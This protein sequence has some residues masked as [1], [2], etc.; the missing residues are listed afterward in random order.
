M[1]GD[2]TPTGELAAFLAD[3]P[4]DGA[5]RGTATDWLLDTLGCI[6]FGAGRPESAAAATHARASGGTGGTA[7]VVGHGFATSPALAAFANGTSGHAFELDDV[8]EEAISHPGAVVVPA[9]LAVAPTV[10][11]SGRTVVDAIVVGYEAMGRAGIAVGPAAHM[12]S[13]FH[14]TG[15]SGVFG[16]AAA[17]GHLLGFDAAT[18]AHALGLAATFA[19]GS[20]EFSQTG[21]STKRFHAGR[22]SEG[23]LTAAM[24][25][26]AGMEG[27]ADGLAGRYG[28]CRTTTTDPRI[29]L[30][31]E[32]LGSRWMVDEVTVKPWAACSDIHPLIDAAVE[33][34]ARGVTADDIA[35]IHAEVP[36]KAAEQN[37]LDGT[38][39]VMAAQYSGPFNVAAAFLADPA[40]PATY[41]P[42]RIAD[43]ALADLQS[44]VVSMRA[45][46]WCDATYAWK[47][48]GSL[49][50][51]C[52]DGTEHEVRVAGQKGSMHQP[53]TADELEQ[54]FRLLVDDRLDADALLA[55]V[56]GLLDAPDARTLLDALA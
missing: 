3:C 46:E 47:M 7:T 8:H 4:V 42:E 1:T 25:A 45:A 29:H 10:G 52:H 28:F 49:R 12:L 9:V 56:R 19:S 6:V 33:I 48:A 53:L 15:Q 26:A 43:P 5:R 51:V 31:T 30:L 50:V 32:D 11:A 27:P 37:A 13:G 22:A 2:R 20:T 35:E 14:P 23:G 55:A 54:K 24:L 16:S 41:T 17:V 18:M 44:R 40:D 21:G 36:T 38:T 39:S 34:R